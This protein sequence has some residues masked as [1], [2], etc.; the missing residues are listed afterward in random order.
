MLNL[1]AREYNSTLRAHSEVK[2]KMQQENEMPPAFLKYGRYLTG[3][4]TIAALSKY[5]RSK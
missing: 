1:D 3:R 5:N 4:G 2:F